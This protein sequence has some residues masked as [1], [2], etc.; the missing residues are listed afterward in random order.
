M[1]KDII[2]DIINLHHQ[3][4][5]LLQFKS[6]ISASQYIRLYSFSKKYLK[7]GDAVLDWG[8]GNGHFSYFLLRS[9]FRT[10]GFSLGELPQI[11]APFVQE[12]YEYRKG[13]KA[14]PVHIPFENKKFD[15]VVS[16]GVLEHVRTTGGDEAS[17]LKEIY[18]VLK[19]HGIFICF[20]LPN[21]LSWIEAVS[22]L[23]NRK[24]HHPYRYTTQD[25]FRLLGE[26]NFAAVEIQ[27][28]ALL[29][30]NIWAQGLMKKLGNQPLVSTLY[31]NLDSL[32]SLILRP[33]C[34][35]YLFIAKKLPQV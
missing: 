20:H 35:N 15:A 17:S 13:D 24:Y 34:Q 23:F 33:F 18:R 25:I 31:N 7:P 14:D 2:N 26:T 32:L 19:D 16:V 3:D 8:V 30:R 29:P 27:R 4:K 11:C 6:L 10:T 21:R 5:S 1:F 28:Y 22:R 9:G 12:S